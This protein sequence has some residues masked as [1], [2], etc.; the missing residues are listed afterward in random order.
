MWNC[1]EL[2]FILFYCVFQ[3]V[4]LCVPASPTV[5]HTQAIVCCISWL[6]PSTGRSVTVPLRDIQ[7]QLS[8]SPYILT[9]DSWHHYL[10]HVQVTYI[11]KWYTSWHK[12]LSGWSRHFSSCITFSFCQVTQRNSVLLCLVVCTGEECGPD[13]TPW[14]CLHDHRCP[15]NWSCPPGGRIP[16][17]VCV[18]AYLCVSVYVYGCVCF[19][20]FSMSSSSESISMQSS[21]IQ[22]ET[23]E[24]YIQFQRMLLLSSI[25]VV[26]KYVPFN[27]APLRSHAM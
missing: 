2:C 23:I 1:G 20:C 26:F 17:C 19:Y 6:L 7:F 8:S 16:T 12:L 27:H 5:S 24:L 11:R 9:P 13:S 25:S 3:P 10:D 15:F 4:Q 22:L 21:S 18:C 14:V